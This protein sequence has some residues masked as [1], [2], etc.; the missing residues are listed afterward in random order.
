MNKI[1]VLLISFCLVL[2]LIG[3]TEQISGPGGNARSVTLVI[4]NGEDVLFSKES[5][6]IVTGTNAFDAVKTML[7]NNLEYQEYDFGVF[8]TSILG[9]TPDST[10]FWSLYIN[11]ENASNG[12]S[13]YNISDDILIEFK[14]EELQTFE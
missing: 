11:G 6:D 7:D 14:L 5:K 1:L 10:H 4:S 3:C 12:I 8:I 13:S 2:S 9:A